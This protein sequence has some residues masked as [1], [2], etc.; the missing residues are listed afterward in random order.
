MP[1]RRLSIQHLFHKL[2]FGFGAPYQG[3]IAFCCSDVYKIVFWRHMFA[4]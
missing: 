4:L 3:R 2:E 1:D